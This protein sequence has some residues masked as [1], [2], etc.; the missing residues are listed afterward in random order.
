MRRRTVEV[1]VLQ[2]P[3][4]Q[5]D[6]SAQ[7]FAHDGAGVGVDARYQV[8]RQHRRVRRH[9]RR[10]VVAGAAEA[11]S[12]VNDQVVAAQLAGLV[13]DLDGVHLA[14]APG[15]EASRDATISTVESWSDQYRDA[16]PVK[17]REHQLGLCRDRATRFTYEGV[18]T[19]TRDFASVALA[20][21]GG[22]E[23]RNHASSPSGAG[24]NVP[25]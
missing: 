17:S 22:T 21:D 19:A 8:D 6:V 9:S 13:R 5:S 16:S 4:G 25:S 10:E 11:E 7:G 15:Q 24:I 20:H 12:G 2:C 18:H 1:G 23:Q 3:Q 14:A